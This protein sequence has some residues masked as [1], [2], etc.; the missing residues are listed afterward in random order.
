AGLPYAAFADPAELRDPELV[1]L[2]PRPGDP[3]DYV[4][5]RA[6]GKL[7]ALTTTCA[8][9][10]LGLTSPGAYAHGRAE[11]ARLALAPLAARLHRSI[12]DAAEGVLRLGAQPE[13]VEVYVEVDGPRQRVRATALGATELRARDLRETISEAEA[14][15]V[16]AGTLAPGHSAPALAARTSG[17]YVFT[18]TRQERWLGL[19]TRTRRPLRVVDRSGFVKLRKGGGVA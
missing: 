14:R 18:A 7:F 9:N 4:A 11:S 16:A 13:T 10:A 1:L 17:L 5:V 19:F 2:S 12:D 6:G 3:D 15:A 8:A